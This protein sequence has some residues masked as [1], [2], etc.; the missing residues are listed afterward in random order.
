LI[1]KCSRLKRYS[2]GEGFTSEISECR[3]Q[4]SD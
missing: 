4:I 2:S 3:V 1:P